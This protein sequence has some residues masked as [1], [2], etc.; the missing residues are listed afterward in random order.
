MGGRDRGGC[1]WYQHH[2]SLASFSSFLASFFFQTFQRPE[3][4]PSSLPFLRFFGEFFFSDFPETRVDCGH[5]RRSASVL[6]RNAPSVRNCGCAA[7]SGIHP[8]TRA[9]GAPSHQRG[10]IF[11]PFFWLWP[12][13]LRSFGSIDKLV[14]CWCTN[15]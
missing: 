10:L 11:L 3:R 13:G 4:T 9:A 7:A 15:N 12:V 6:E 14:R 8:G 5:R 2:P 1:V